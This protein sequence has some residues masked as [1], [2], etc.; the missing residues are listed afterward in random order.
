MQLQ[1]AFDI[2]DAQI[3]KLNKEIQALQ[4]ARDQLTLKFTPELT[5]IGDLRKELETKSIELS[6]IIAEK[7]APPEIIP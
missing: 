1:E 6:K 7:I 3:Y 2:I 5:Q 4:L